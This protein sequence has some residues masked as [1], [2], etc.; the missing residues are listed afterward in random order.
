MDGFGRKEVK[1]VPQGSSW[2]ETDISWCLW[3]KVRYLWFKV[4]FK[5]F[6]NFERGRTPTIKTGGKRGVYGTRDADLQKAVFQVI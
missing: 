5:L 4:R 1:S 6:L 3:F 2:W